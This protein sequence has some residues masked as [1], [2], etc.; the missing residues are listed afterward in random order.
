MALEID[1]LKKLCM[2][3]RLNAA[4]IISLVTLVLDDEGMLGYQ[5]SAKK[6]KIYEARGNELDITLRYLTII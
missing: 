6:K 4:E 2:Q 3:L 5:P 1:D